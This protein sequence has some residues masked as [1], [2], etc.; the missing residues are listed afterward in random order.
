MEHIWTML[1]HKILQNH[2]LCAFV[3]ILKIGGIYALYPESFC[4]ENLAIQK[5]FAFCDSEKANHNDTTLEIYNT[6]LEIQKTTWEIQNTTLE[7]GNTL[8][9][10]INITKT[11]PIGGVGKSSVSEALRQAIAILPP[12]AQGMLISRR[13]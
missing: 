2:L 13:I 10:K 8:H 1:M 7:I 6:T 5:V 11:R 12:A 3:A 4:D 9:W